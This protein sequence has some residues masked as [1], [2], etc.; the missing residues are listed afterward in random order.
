[1]SLGDTPLPFFNNRHYVTV[2]LMWIT[3]KAFW[4]KRLHSFC[5]LLLP[6]VTRL[7]VLSLWAA[8]NLQSAFR[9]LHFTFAFCVNVGVMF[10]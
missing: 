10:L 5:I 1:M 3:W 9:S 8:A 2:A 6:G 7:Y 4:W